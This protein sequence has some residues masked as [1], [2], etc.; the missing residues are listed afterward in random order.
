M[1]I[2]AGCLDDEPSLAPQRTIFWNDRA[3]WF[4]PACRAARFANYEDAVE[5]QD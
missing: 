3:L 5:D 1:I 2:P 4:E